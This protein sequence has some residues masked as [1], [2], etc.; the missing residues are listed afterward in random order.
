MTAQKIPRLG[1]CASIPNT[2]PH[3]FPMASETNSVVLMTHSA[4]E[5]DALVAKFKAKGRQVVQVG[6]ITMAV[7]SSSG[8]IDHTQIS[9]MMK[10][11]EHQQ[12]TNKTRGRL[13]QKLFERQ[14]NQRL[15]AI[16]DV[17]NKHDLANKLARK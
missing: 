7:Q 14:M 2:F 6:D 17:A 15:Q 13:A 10:E 9:W 11:Q 4:D 8:K 16:V 12:N 5:K 1:W 3:L